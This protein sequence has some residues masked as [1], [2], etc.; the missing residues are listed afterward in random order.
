MNAITKLLEYKDMNKLFLMAMLLAFDDSYAKNAG[1]FGGRSASAP[2]TRAAP[3][4]ATRA[5]AFG[6]RSANASV[7]GNTVSG[8]TAGAITAKSKGTL[9]GA[10]KTG[11]DAVK[12]FDAFKAKSQPPIQANG[13]LRMDDVDRIFKPEYRR[14]RR[15]QFYADYEP[16]QKV[17]HYVEER[18]SFGPWDSMMLWSMLDRGDRSMYY[19]HQDDDNFKSWRTQAEEAAKTDPE[20]AKKLADLDKDMAQRKAK[21][22]KVNP[23]YVTPGVDPDIY[24]ANNI[25]PKTLK[26]LKICTGSI[27]ADYNRY[28]NQIT[29]VTKLKVSTVQSNGTVDN[30]AKLATGECDLAFAQSDVASTNLMQLV[31]LTQLEGTLLFCGTTKEKAKVDI[32]DIS[33]ATVYIGSDQTGSQ[34]TF[35]KLR[36]SIPKLNSVKI[37]ASLPISAAAQKILGDDKACVFAVVTPRAPFITSIDVKNKAVLV[38]IEKSDFKASPTYPLAWV[39]SKYFKNLTQDRFMGFG[40]SGTNTVAVGTV[41]LTSSSWME[42]NKMLYDLLVMESRNLQISLQ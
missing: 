31:R 37:D 14:E 40:D 42:Q 12:L 23:G 8:N 11:N 34:Y 21:G 18:P 39:D 36:A 19:N 3:A 24:E 41:V 13:K 32:A 15:Q 1:S 22:E 30:L 16:P 33:S 27:S 5:S 2:A 35:E 38:P 4:T 28:A 9:A 7:S 26:E 10:G 6:G 17:I 25:D 29:K 20:I